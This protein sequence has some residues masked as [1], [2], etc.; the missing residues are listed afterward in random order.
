[1]RVADGD[2]LAFFAGAAERQFELFAHSGY[3]GDIVQEGNI[4][5]A[6]A[7]AVT[8]RG[9]K[10]HGGGGGAAVDVKKIV[11][12][13]DGH[14]LGHERRI[15]GG[16]RALMIVY[17]D[18]AGD[19]A[20]KLIDERRNLE[21]GHARM[22]FLR[23]G[24]FVADG[25]HREMEHDLITAAMSFLGDFD[26]VFVIGE[27]G[28]GERVGEGKNGLGS[29]AVGAEIV[30]DDGEAGLACCSVVIFCL[31]SWRRT[32]GGDFNLVGDSAEAA[33]SQDQQ[34]SGVNGRILG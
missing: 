5:E 7:H 31:G 22:K 6:G 16:L 20:E 28:D 30:E 2:G 14:K 10:G 4:A 8:L 33:E 11:L 29:G 17:A 15:G 9:V 25:L 27:H 23:F 32:I 19:V 18:D 13:E 3:L 21:L 12:T 1:M 24:L 34:G 26:G